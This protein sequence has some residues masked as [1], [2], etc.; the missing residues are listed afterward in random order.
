ME[1]DGSAIFSIIIMICGCVLTLLCV[2]IEWHERYLIVKAAE[3]A[4]KGALQVEMNHYQCLGDANPKPDP[5]P[6]P[7]PGPK[8]M[9]SLPRSS[10]T[11]RPP[12]PV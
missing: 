8:P 2:C 11:A 6:D 4:N 12:P 3:V 1:L 5:K 9:P 7:K 10:L